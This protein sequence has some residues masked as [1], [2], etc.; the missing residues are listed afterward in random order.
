M[1][2]LR[3][4]YAGTPEFAVPALQALASS[5]HRPLLVI[6]Q[7]DRRAGRGRQ[8]TASAVKLEA[9]EAQIT[10][11]QP[12][13]VNNAEFLR[14]LG[15][16]NLDLLVVAAFGQL[17]SSD[18]LALPKLGCINIHASLLPR[19]RGAS[20]IQHA[21]LA[22]DSHTGVSIMQMEQRMDAG[23]I[24]LQSRCQIDSSDTA[25]SLH[26][27]LAALSADAILNAI[28]LIAAG[29]GSAQ[30][31]NEAQASYC[32]KLQKKDGLIRW[33]ESA[34]TILRKIR[35]F[36]PWPG[37]YTL[38]KGRRLVI[39]DATE[40]EPAQPANRHQPGTVI[41]AGHQGLV[42][43][44]GDH[45]ICIHELIPAGGKRMRAGDFAHSNHILQAV[46]GDA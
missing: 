14:D 28:E 8:L 37:A 44:T 26:A 10:V 11:L 15:E 22:G 33:P 5:R 40:C 16:Q 24:W 21:I 30:P 20:P 1:K 36:Y 34:L 6:T 18:L 17:F 23:A 2:G 38:F 31:Q 39:T 3:L 46:L 12:A 42:V 45:P 32:A 19:W 4:A 35:A 9:Q 7:P 13:D 41:D 29:K 27:K 25:Q 43:A